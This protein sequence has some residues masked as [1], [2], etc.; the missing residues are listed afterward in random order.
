MDREARVKDFSYTRE[1]LDEIEA[2]LSRE[3]L[4]AYLTAAR[5]DRARAI[6]L[7]AW[8]TAVSAAFYGPLQGLE[9]TL[10]D[11]RAGPRRGLQA[12]PRCGRVDIADD[13][14]VDRAPWPGFRI[15]CAPE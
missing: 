6:R 2:A 15:T 5:G 1:I 12:H 10:T 13:G 11:L 8:N 14:D 3:R 7:H 9:I 4:S